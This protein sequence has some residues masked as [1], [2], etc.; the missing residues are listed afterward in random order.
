MKKY[1]EFLITAEPFNADVLSGIL[2]ELDITGLNED[3]DCLHVF[4]DAISDLNKEAINNQLKKLEAEGLLETFDVEESELEE[5]NWNEEWE[6]S[7][8]IIRVTDRIVVRPSSRS[9]KKK[10][11]EIVIT[12]DPKMSFGTGEHQ[13]TRL[14]IQ[15]LEKYIEPGMKILDVGTGTGILTIA[16]VKLGAVKA[17][18]VDIDEWCYENAKE[19]CHINKVNSKVEIRLG[20]ISIIPETDFDL[21][22]ANIQKNI[23]LEF[24][25][26][27]FKK[28]RTGGAVLLS[29]LLKED[30][31]DIFSDYTQKGFRH[32][33]TVQMDEWIAMSFGKS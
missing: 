30:E 10:K 25:D 32:N 15:L 11:N 3:A 19:N 6:K 5:K 28:L 4:T 22:L 29:G 14:V 21:I 7:L 26:N 13:T 20:N 17:I 31:V 1:K 23:L 27:F 12:I 18:G 33:E 8:N 9:Y 2:W 24:S 16:S